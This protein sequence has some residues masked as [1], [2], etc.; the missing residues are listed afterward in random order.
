MSAQIFQVSTQWKHIHITIFLLCLNQ[1]FYNLLNGLSVVLTVYQISFS[2]FLLQNQINYPLNGDRTFLNEIC[3][4]KMKYI[5]SFWQLW[6]TGFW[7]ELC[8]F[9]HLESC[10]TSRRKKLHDLKCA[11]PQENINISA[12]PNSSRNHEI[13]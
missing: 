4:K 3:L 13:F 5:S 11:V 9:H 8:L 10:L 7:E 1:N 12:S 6:R 2:F